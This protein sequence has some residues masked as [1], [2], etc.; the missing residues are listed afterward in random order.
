MAVRVSKLYGLQIFDDK[1]KFIGTVADIVLDLQKGEI[2]RITTEQIPLSKKMDDQ[3]ISNIIKNSVLYKNVKSVG[4]I[5]IISKE[6][7][8]EAPK[9]SK[10]EEEIE[11]KGFFSKLVKRD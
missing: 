2:I 6:K 4:D 8:E 1:G 3:S 9:V 10:K 5:M 7:G 11:R